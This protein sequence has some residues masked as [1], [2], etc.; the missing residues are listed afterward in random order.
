MEKPGDSTME[1]QEKNGDRLRQLEGRVKELEVRIES[2]ED[3]VELS[4]GWTEE[5]ED[6]LELLEERVATL[7]VQN[8]ELRD[9]IN[10]V[11]DVVNSVTQ[12][13][14][15]ISGTPP[16]VD[17]QP[18]LTVQQVYDMYQS[19]PPTEE[20]WQEMTDAIKAAEEYEAQPAQQLFNVING[21]TPTEWKDLLQIA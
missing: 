11:I 5:S 19:Q 20:D 21:L 15:N 4:D 16:P 2:L 10:S 3:S 6:K 1:D 7:N 18:K 9:H 13:L 14:N 12:I 8:A 17:D